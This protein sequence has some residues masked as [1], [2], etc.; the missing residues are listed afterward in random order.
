MSSFWTTK[1]LTN[2]VRNRI[3]AEKTNSDLDALYAGE[4]CRLLLL[5]TTAKEPIVFFLFVTNDKVILFSLVVLFSRI[6]RNTYEHFARNFYSSLHDGTSKKTSKVPNSFV[7]LS[8]LLTC[9]KNFKFIL[10]VRRIVL[11]ITKM[12]H[13]FGIMHS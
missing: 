4:K 6:K 2:K 9:T 8:Q 11:Q 10:L 12:N 7:V 5:V 1:F 3:Q 13:L